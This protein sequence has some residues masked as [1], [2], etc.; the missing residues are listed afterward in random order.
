MPRLFLQLLGT[1]SL[2]D[3]DGVVPPSLGWGKPLALLAVLAIR[4]EARRDEIVDLLWRDVEEGKARNAFRQALHRLRS[5]LG[6]DLLPQDREVL[7]LVR[8]AD[9]AVDLDQFDAAVAE[10][11]IDD[12]IRLYRGDFLEGVELGEAPFDQWADQERNR[13]RARF[14][15]VLEQAIAA[16]QAAGA[17]TDAITHSRRLLE[18]A[19]YDEA[20]ARLG[21]LTLVS[22]GRRAEARDLVLQFASRLNADLGLD[23]PAELRSLVT[24][25]D[26]TGDTAVSAVPATRADEE[27]PFIGRES[28]LSQLLALWRQTGEDAG[29]LAI[30]E[31]GQGMG[32]SRLVQEFLVNARSLAPALVL[33]GRERPHAARVPFALFAEALRPAVRAQGIMGAS[34]HLLAEAAR[35]LPEL[36]DSMDLPPVADV[37]DET[38]RVR[39]FEGVAALI[40]AA[41][42]ERPVLMA[43]EDLHHVG[44]SSLDLLSYLVARLAGSAVM[45]VLTLDPAL[46]APS[47]RDRIRLLVPDDSSSRARRLQLRPLGHH[48]V[49]ELLTRLRPRL[50]ATDA[51]Q[52]T[53]RAGGAPGRLPDLLRRLDAGEDL[54]QLPVSVRSLAADRLQQLSSSQRRSFLVLAL[55]GRPVTEDALAAAAH[56]SRHAVDETVRSLRGEG[57]L[58]HADAGFLEADDIA[59]EVALETAGQPSRAFLAGWIAE[60]L[61]A[62]PKSHP[63][64]LARFCSLA[65]RQ[66]DAFT[67]SRRAAFAAMRVGAWVEAV[68]HLQMARGFAARPNEI[69]DIEGILAALGAGHRRI[70]A[71]PADPGLRVEDVSTAPPSAPVPPAWQR[72]FPNW[73]LLLGGAVA[74]LLISAFVMWRTPPAAV[75]SIPTTDTLVVLEGEPAR[76]AR[77]VTGDLATGFRLSAPIPI[78]GTA[79]A[80]VDSLERPW[81]HAIPSPRSAAVALT[82]VGSPLSDVRV[83]S[84]DRRDTT[85]LISSGGEARPLGWSPDG[86][87]VLVV[88]SFSKTAGEMDA[89]L[90][91]IRSDGSV[92]MPIDTAAH[93][94]VVEA[95]WSPDG[96]RIAWVARIGDERQQD[97]FV[98]RADG[99]RSENLTRHP[100]DDFHLSWSG[101]GELLGF[102]STRD[103]NAELYAIGMR[104]RRL[105]RLTQDPAQ[106][107]FARFSRSGRFVAFESTRGGRSGLYVMAALGGQARRLG[108][109]ELPLS[110]HDWRGA[111]H[112][113]VDRIR[114]EASPLAVGD[115][116]LLR[117]SAL[118]QFGEPMPAPSVETGVLDEGLAELLRDEQGVER[119]VGRSPGIA[120]IVADIGRWRLDT[121]IVRIGERR[122]PI[123][124]GALAPATWRS[125]GE[126]R[127]VFDPAGV[128]LLADRE[129]ESGIL[130]RAAAPLIPDLEASVTIEGSA[131]AFSSARFSVALVA[132]EGAATLDSITPQFLRYASF[133]WDAEARRAVYSVGREVHA[134][135]VPP[136]SGTLL[137]VR[138][139]VESDS[140]VSFHL[141]G[142]LR[143]RSTVRVVTA[144]SEPQAQLWIGAR[145]T[146]EALRLRAAELA[147]RGASSR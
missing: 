91:A 65:G 27:S 63:A 134:D 6:E 125:L 46:T 26:R 66:H 89:D 113:F 78:P 21:A 115:T 101:D 35:L 53:H 147:L 41:A 96:S 129:W 54:A 143:W 86:R 73:R 30:V 12:A 55:F 124:S 16:S 106:D 7:R 107:D 109:S 50:S 117:V 45:F 32:K 145:S 94:S 87:W 44:Q 68:S 62:D 70:A 17:W 23:L 83:I 92:G 71:T 36:R 56:L 95:A 69:A 39:F 77:I 114:V 133:T 13:F 59:A 25:L 111:P 119:M 99:S 82:R 146:G 80:W 142:R 33:A 126:P 3:A 144:S 103:G 9:L 19:P 34:R 120:R 57:L 72:W 81:S 51:E 28:E 135:A 105:W 97:V 102:T 24:R 58:R 122:E 48:E 137:E 5:A 52:V 76:A 60:S 1:P 123:V 8:S 93:R 31:A 43:L 130:S 10:A 74:T 40:D 127:P 136:V 84:G 132:P 20:A 4:G 90:F 121:A 131:R 67:F 110:V 108:A 42:Y 98:S 47:T 112:R 14:R 11:R 140:T 29:T 118:D 49:R 15:G 38:A 18:I 104:E 75:A 139:L 88:V 141:D 116:A 128:I 79:P 85:L 61:A 100:A 37:E 64:E 138:L 22:A 2:R